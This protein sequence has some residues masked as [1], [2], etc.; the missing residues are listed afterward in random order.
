MK[1]LVKTMMIILLFNIGGNAGAQV[2]S[3]AEMD[4]DVGIE[5]TEIEPEPS[6]TVPNTKKPIV[7][8]PQTGES[9]S[10]SNAIV[11]GSIAI[12]ASWFILKK[13]EEVDSE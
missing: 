3:G 13:R 9:T 4:T 2:S 1:G 6:K 8:L 12:I 10:K 5:F 11:G 7:K